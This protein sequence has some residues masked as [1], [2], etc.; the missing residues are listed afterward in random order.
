MKKI[1]SLALAVVVTMTGCTG[2]AVPASSPSLTTT[3]SPSPTST[4]PQGL[5]GRMRRCL[6]MYTRN[7][8]RR[9]NVMH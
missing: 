7:R 2:R 3:A 8:A 5:R 4:A 6:Q 9:S 1:T